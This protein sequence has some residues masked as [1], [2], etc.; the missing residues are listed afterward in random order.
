MQ[1]S[2][3]L[4]PK[5]TQY[6]IPLNE[7]N[8]LPNFNSHCWANSL[9]QSLLNLPPV[10][11]ILIKSKYS[12]NNIISELLKI[13]ESKQIFGLLKSIINQPHSQYFS[14]NGPQSVDE[15][16]TYLL[17]A[18]SE[19]SPLFALRYGS[20]GK[21]NFH[22]R[23][24][25]FADID[26]YDIKMPSS[27]CPKSLEEFILLRSSSFDYPNAC[28]KDYKNY[29]HLIK[30][31]KIITITRTNI[32]NAFDH[33]QTTL[34]L[35]LKSSGFANFKLSAIIYYTG[36][37][38]YAIIDRNNKLYNCN[39]SSITQVSSF[40]ISKFINTLFYTYTGFSN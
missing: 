33:L 28:C 30:F 25:N 31:S 20:F 26:S 36:G 15:A 29:T 34:R 14:T 39:D 38:Y 7:P 2:F 1:E 21:C 19:I 22:N 23:I 13:P 6:F 17:N 10:N 12:Q 40:E 24:N 37:H 5:N 4:H 18:C 16:L 9:I 27:I 32:G 35:P 8:G 11:E 3:L